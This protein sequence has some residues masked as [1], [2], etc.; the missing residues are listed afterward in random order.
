MTAELLTDEIIAVDTWTHIAAVREYGTAL[1]VYI[2]GEPSGS[3]VDNAGEVPFEGE[4]NHWSLG[5]HS[6]THS[7]PTFD[8]FAGS[9]TEI[10]LWNGVRT[11]AEIN[12]HIDQRIDASSSG[13]DGYW[14]L[15][16]GSGYDASELTGF[17]A[18]GLFNGAPGWR[19]DAACGI[20]EPGGLICNIDETSTDADGDTIGYDFAWDVNGVEFDG[21]VSRDRDF[22]TVLDD[23]VVASDLWTC[24]VTPFDEE[25]PGEFSSVQYEVDEWTRV[26]LADT[27][28]MNSTALDYDVPIDEWPAGVTDARIAFLNPTTGELSNATVFPIPSAWMTQSPMQYETGYQ[29]VSASV[30]GAASVSATLLYGYNNWGLSCTPSS[31][32]DSSSPPSGRIAVCTSGAAY[33]GRFARSGGGGD[34]CGVYPEHNSE[35]CGATRLFGIWV[36]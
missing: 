36:R 22:D 4:T 33:W 29:T 17:A 18:M 27:W 9:M 5:R 23:D 19:S 28:D 10:R 12:D 34:N 30:N 21:A 2:N 11:E 24:E 13:L 8:P 3:V 7:P 26:F 32:F 25:E 14:P 35:S 1:T 16:D 6:D 20:Y 31:W 15:N